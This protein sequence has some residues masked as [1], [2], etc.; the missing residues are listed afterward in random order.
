MTATPSAAAPPNWTVRPLHSEDEGRWRE[1][2]AG[3]AAFYKVEQTE[4]MASRVWGWLL[5]PTHSV[6][7]IV[8]VDRSSRVQGLAHYR[9]FA[10]PSSASMGGYLDDLFVDPELRGEGAADLLL[11]EL[12]RIGRERNW[13]IIRWITADDNYRARGK[14]DQFPSARPGLRTTCSPTLHDPW[15]FRTRA[16]NRRFWRPGTK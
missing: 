6:E 5:D 12:K 1:L 16:W 7:G 9:D 15:R 13:T 11:K 2:Y 8:A 4:A 14:Y 10:R 3:Y